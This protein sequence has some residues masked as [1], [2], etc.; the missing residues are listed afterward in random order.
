MKKQ[1]ERTFG[2]LTRRWQVFDHVPDT[3]ELVANGWIQ[4][5]AGVGELYASLP[6]IRTVGR[7]TLVTQWIGYD[8]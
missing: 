3:D 5:N 6:H 1:G 8:V 7:R 4:Y 2:D